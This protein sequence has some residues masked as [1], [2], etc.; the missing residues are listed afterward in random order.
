[1]HERMVELGGEQKRWMDLVRWDNNGKIDMSTYIDRASFNKAIH[2]LLP[3]PQSERD[4]NQNLSQ[5]NG[6]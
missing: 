3:I 4:I 2:K 5:N 1:M 6:Y